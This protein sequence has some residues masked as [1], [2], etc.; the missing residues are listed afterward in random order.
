MNEIKI[1]DNEEFGTIRTPRATGKGQVY[2]INKFL[3][4]TSN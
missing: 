2:F 3:S 4:T 1:F